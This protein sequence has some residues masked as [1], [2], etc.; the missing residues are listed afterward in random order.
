MKIN[1]NKNMQ[2]Y[3]QKNN[4]AKGIKV[5]NEDANRLNLL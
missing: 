5:K 3:K 4:N 2:K 1:K